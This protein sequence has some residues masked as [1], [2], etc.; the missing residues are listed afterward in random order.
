MQTS[1]LKFIQ[2][3]PAT[4]LLLA[5]GIIS[6]FAQL[7]PSGTEIFNRAEA[8]Y[9]DF[10][11]NRLSTV[12]QTVSFIVRSVPRLTVSPDE[13]EPTAIVGANERIVR[14]FKV[15]NTGNVADT[16]QIARS[17]ISSPS[18]FSGLYFD[19]DDN[20]TISNADLPVVLNQ[21]AK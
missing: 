12:S 21:N 15:C 16:Y 8:D 6:V 13:T 11:G 14:S 3:M 2:I 4:L 7:T 1:K 17:N 19:I 10:H 9:F 18:A 5:F 20:G